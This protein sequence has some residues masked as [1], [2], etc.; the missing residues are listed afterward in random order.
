MLTLPPAAPSLSSSA[1]SND[2]SSDQ[3]G[4]EVCFMPAGLLLQKLL[5]RPDGPQAT[6]AQAQT[7]AA[8]TAELLS[9][10]DGTQKHG[11]ARAATTLGAPLGSWLRAAKD[12][13]SAGPNL[14]HHA[15]MCRSG[16]RSM[17]NRDECNATS[18]HDTPTS[19]EQGFTNEE[20][21]GGQ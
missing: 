3:V 10:L 8:A 15:S 13:L 5:H 18:C 20:L 6:S 12:G 17:P 21:D 14:P 2:S 9:L 4:I 16:R 19:L 11:A 1:R 7:L